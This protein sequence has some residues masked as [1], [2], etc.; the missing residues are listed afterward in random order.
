MKLVRR[1]PMKAKCIDAHNSSGLL[2]KG[3]IYEIEPLNDTRGLCH[4]LDKEFAAY[5]N[6]SM[7]RFE[8]LRKRAV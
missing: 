4:I 8:V 1:L 2:R 7:T 5:P 6:W 3:K